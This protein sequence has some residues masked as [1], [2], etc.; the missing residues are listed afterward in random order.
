[1]GI[2]VNASAAP[3]QNQTPNKKS[4]RWYVLK[5]KPRAE[6]QCLAELD[7]KAIESLC[8]MVMEYRLRRRRLEK[9]PMFPGYVFARFA[10]PE[11]HHEVRWLK[12]VN[13]L[14]RFGMAGPPSLPEELVELF[15][16]KMDEEGIF[17]IKQEF[18]PGDPVK[19][20]FGPF[21]GLFGKI[22]RAD[23]A[24]GRVTVLMELLYQATIQAATFQV[25]A[26]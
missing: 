9:T 23:A 22:L 13:D 17:E 2:I 8:P 24:K 21:Q 4:V 20:I 6:G 1:M 14:V 16:S 11:E 5:T 26:I 25:K 12:G 3:F 10:W 7:R 18:T 19:F 15:S